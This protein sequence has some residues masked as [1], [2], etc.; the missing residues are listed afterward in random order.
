MGASFKKP[1]ALLGCYGLALAWVITHFQIVLDISEFMP[2]GRGVRESQLSKALTQGAASRTLIV[3][4]TGGSE[5]SSTEAST[6]L[7]DS[8]GAQENPQWRIETGPEE[9]I[10]QAMWELY[11]PRSLS[12]IASST[13]ALAHKLSDEGLE[14]SLAEL[15]RRLSGPM[16]SLYARA[17]PED[18]FL[19][20]LGLFDRLQ[21][22][23]QGGV[24]VINNVFFSKDGRS[25]VLFIH[26]QQSAFSGSVHT[27][28]LQ[29]ISAAVDSFQ[30]QKDPKLSYKL[31]GAHPFSAKIEAGIKADI[32]RVSVI[33]T[34]GL[35]A[36]FL[37]LFRRP[38]VIGLT[39]LILGT[40]VIGGLTATLLVFGQIHGLTLAFGASLIGVA[41]DYS[42]HYLTHR[43]LEDSSS[44][45]LATMRRIWPGLL[46]GALTTTLGF[47]AL[48]ASGLPGLRQVSVFASGGIL[49][50]L[51]STRVL[52]P[53]LMP[54]QVG[55]R[56]VSSLGKTI[57]HTLVFLDSLSAKILWAV[58][59][60]GILIAAVVLPRLQWQDRV[61]QMAQLDQNLLADQNYVR[62]Q[63]APYEEQKFVVSFGATEDLAL[64]KNARVAQE[65]NRLRQGGAISGFRSIELLLPSQT[66]QKILEQQ[67]SAS[68]E[69]KQRFTKA[70]EAVGFR[71]EAFAPFFKK[72]AADAPVPL[73]YQ[74][75]HDSPLKSAV[76][77]FRLELPDGVAF[78]SY[79][80]Q[81]KDA[82]KLQ[83]TIQA[84]P[85]AYYLDLGELTY[86][87]GKNYRKDT[88][89]GLLAGLL[90]VLLVIY[91][92]Y[93]RLSLALAASLPA[94]LALL[95]TLS[96]LSLLS[97][98]LDLVAL[99]ALLMVFSMGI[100]YGVFLAESQHEDELAGTLLALCIAWAST[101]L[102]FGLLAL[103]N[104]PAMR[105]IGVTASIGVTSSLLIA[106]LTLLLRKNL[107][108]ES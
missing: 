44:D 73:N 75:L 30:K 96:V 62:S 64:Q 98:S 47:V 82:G 11:A 15:Q 87:S 79:L 23:N 65:L 27:A 70:A 2:T 100:D 50:A 12:L 17:A 84:I 106:P 103:S 63:V 10:E 24:Q 66:L 83:K 36:L 104:H 45:R 90:S 26:T 94:V 42:V 85:E 16:G 57:R 22:S 81:V 41:I 3:L 32:Q 92:R 56:I 69:L 108:H 25:S 52:L 31:A 37:L 38:Q 13:Q 51:L 97:I 4:L 40:G 59:G 107:N 101:L 18:P 28:L 99:T 14:T 8:L 60:A 93:Q 46:L 105:T 53:A 20:A 33:S 78:I 9:G 43:A 77:S 68:P 80:N 7:A 54:L 39:L 49:S 102:G 61:S 19:A 88:V 6:Y 76:S 86:S 95:L 91:L 29:T 34:L 58:A 89:W 72:L 48:S 67:V 5:K 21:A 1:A 71:A 55:S 35:L 74:M